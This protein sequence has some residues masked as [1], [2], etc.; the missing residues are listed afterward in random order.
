M[1]AYN[2]SSDNFGLNVGFEAAGIRVLSRR[3]STDLL[4]A[5]CRHNEIHTSINTDF[6]DF[7]AHIEDLNNSSLDAVIG[8]FSDSDIHFLR[9]LSYLV[10]ATRTEWFCIEIPEKLAREKDYQIA[11]KHFK[12]HGYGLTEIKLDASFYEVAQKRERLIIVGRLQEMDGFLE[13]AIIKEG[14]EERHD[15]RS[16][17][18]GQVASDKALLDH[19]RYY[20][21]HA[22]HI[23]IEQIKRPCPEFAYPFFTGH[24]DQFEG[25]QL[26][27]SQVS[28][29]FSVPTSF[30]WKTASYEE[31]SFYEKGKEIEF[32]DVL[33]HNLDDDEIARILPTLTPPAFAYHLGSVMLQRDRGNNVPDLNPAFEKYLADKKG[34]TE[35]AINNLRSRVNRGRKLLNGRTFDSVDDEIAALEKVSDFQ[36]ISGS[37]QS[38]IRRALMLYAELPKTKSKYEVQRQRGAL[39]ERLQKPSDLYHRPTLPWRHDDLRLIPRKP[40]G[41]PKKLDVN[42]NAIQIPEDD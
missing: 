1:R 29:A 16:I 34:Y 23:S 10:S 4:E 3:R 33:E 28:K 5:L 35:A 39:A 2:F 22:Q 19:G 25:L 6:G 13:D 27:I 24:A 30:K 14:S 41:R 15:F 11:R 17:L 32:E 18:S 31:K 8:S 7:P 37:Q 20:F 12:K 26:T 9:E 42:L 38:D 40:R 36:K 21:R